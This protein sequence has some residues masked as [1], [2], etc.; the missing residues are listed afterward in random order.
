MI[1]QL[2]GYVRKKERNFY[3]FK[4]LSFRS[5]KPELHLMTTSALYIFLCFSFK[6]GHFSPTYLSEH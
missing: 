6:M 4:L 1:S 5:P 2:G 3:S